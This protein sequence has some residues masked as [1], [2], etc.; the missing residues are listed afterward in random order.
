LEQ[1]YGTVGMGLTR[2]GL[3]PEEEGLK[4]LTT[5]DHGLGHR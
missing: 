3:A 4:H 1:Q 2:E 5:M